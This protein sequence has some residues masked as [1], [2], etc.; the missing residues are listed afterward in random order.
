MH[1]SIQEAPSHEKEMRISMASIAATPP[2]PPP[3]LGGG[4]PGPTGAPPSSHICRRHPNR[5]LS[6][7]DIAHGYNQRPDRREQDRQ[8]KTL[9]ATPSSPKQPECS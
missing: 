1:I 7:E 3:P 8:C 9:R 4:P 5:Q 6:Q 2:P